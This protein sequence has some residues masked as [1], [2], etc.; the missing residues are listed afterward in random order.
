MNI[1]TLLILPV[2]EHSISFHLFVLSST[3]FIDVL[4]FSEYRSLSF[5]V[6][7]ISRYFILFDV[8]ANGILFLISLSDS[9]L[10]VYRNATDFCK[11][12]LYP[13]TLLN[14]PMTLFNSL[15]NGETSKMLQPLGE[16]TEESE[17]STS[18]FSAVLSSVT[19]T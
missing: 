16:I 11:L 19:M 5:L 10:L 3:S 12:I 6:K 17:K 18:L 2:H 7:F 1:L 9:S 14:S 15:I 8:I 4:E 13:A